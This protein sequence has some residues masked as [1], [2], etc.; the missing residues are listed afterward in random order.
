MVGLKFMYAEL[1]I[2]MANYIHKHVKRRSIL[3]GI[4]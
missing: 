2:W 3:P 4:T 1:W